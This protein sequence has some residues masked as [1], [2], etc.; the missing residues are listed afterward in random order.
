MSTIPVMLT[1]AQTIPEV[2]AR[3]LADTRAQMTEV[4]ER[5]RRN[6]PTVLAT[7]A[8]GSSDNAAEYGGRLLA[9]RCGYLP[10]S[11]PPSLITVERAQIR[12]ANTLV[13]GVSQS[14]RS[15][16]LVLPVDAARAGG[17]DT[18]ALVNVTDSPLAEAAETVLPIGAGPEV[19]V[20]ATKSFVLTLIQFAHLAALLVRDE[21]LITALDALPATLD[22]ALTMDWSPALTA[23]A[24]PA[25]R[26]AVGRGLGFPI[27]REIALKF[28]EVCG[29]HTEA[30]SGAEVMHGP[31]ALI[32][33]ADPIF[34]VAPG[35]RGGTAMRGEI[36]ALAALS[37]NVIVA[38]QSVDGSALH[39]PIPVAPHPALS[40][41]ILATAAYPFI[42]ELA[43]IRGLSPDAPRHLTKVTETL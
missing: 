12:W 25:P 24:D 35:D 21:D 10:A 36:A 19:A 31:K 8:R 5:I 13:I 14:G 20:A 4:A 38:G 15:P 22:E 42:V 40:S 2:A 3:T 28:K 23:L 32:G 7:V 18:V 27:A 16:D 34:C 26:Y 6:D 30:I 41:I 43:Q 37:S 9:Q 1:E 39:L 17:A 11:M 33:R 29:L